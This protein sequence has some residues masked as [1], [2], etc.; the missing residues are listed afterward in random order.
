MAV[1]TLKNVKAKEDRVQTEAIPESNGAGAGHTQ[2]KG[3]KK[4]AEGK[5]HP[6]LRAVWHTESEDDVA[7]GQEWAPP[8]TYH[9][10]MELLGWEWEPEEGDWGED[11]FA[12]SPDGRKFRLKNNTDNRPF[13][14]SR[15]MEYAQTF[16]H[17]GPGLPEE[18]RRWQVNGETMTFYDDGQ[19]ASA[20]HRGV[21]FVYAC[22]LWAGKDRKHW[23]TIWPEEPVYTGLVVYGPKHAPQVSRTYDNVKQRT[24]ADALYT[25]RMF[26]QVS[27]SERLSMAKSLE[28]CVRLLWHRLGMKNNPWAPHMTVPEAMDF[29]DRHPRAVKCVTFIHAQDTKGEL[30]SL[31]LHRG[32]AAALMYLMAASSSEYD[33]YHFPKGKK[34]P[35]EKL[36]DF[37]AWDVAEEFW[38]KV[39]EGHPD[40][41]AL[42]EV[43]AEVEAR[44]GAAPTLSEKCV[45]M[46]KA[47]LAFSSGESMDAES[48]A[49]K[50]LE[51]REYRIP[52]LVEFPDCGGIDRGEPAKKEAAARFVESQKKKDTRTPTQKLLDAAGAAEEDAEEEEAA[53]EEGWDDD[54]EPADEE[55]E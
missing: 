51:D 26:R 38:Q 10:M 24:L 7:E 36:A 31:K 1:K 21:G 22:L 25:D 52:C 19:C 33:K 37:S 46:T 43:M 12:A 45:A 48:L 23:E 28:Q 3:R 8:I 18:K 39:C 14:Q 20:Q 41:D 49:L 47:W 17:S 6:K 30:S 53:E 32:T 55:D 9:R 5:K 42:S 16:L 15:A 2:A 35:T 29:I 44:T 50:Y 11:Y 40:T 13:G 27:Q 34:L 54:V 4:A